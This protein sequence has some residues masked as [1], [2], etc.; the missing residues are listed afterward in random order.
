MSATA[1]CVVAAAIAGAVWPHPAPG[2]QGIA[3][4]G[5]VLVTTAFTEIGGGGFTTTAEDD[6]TGI[7]LTAD[8][9]ILTNNHVI[10]GATSVTVTDP[11]S[12]R[13]YP[14][15]VV[16][17]SV[18][19]DLAVIRLEGASGLTPA[20]L[21]DS[22][23]LSVGTAVTG[24]GNAH[25]DGLLRAASGAVI[26]LDQAV[27]VQSAG[28]GAPMPMSGMIVD[29][30]H[31]VEG[32]SGGPLLD[33][34]GRV[35]GV[36][37]ASNDGDPYAD[38]IASMAIPIE[39]ALSIVTRIRS[40]H[41]EGTVHVGPTASLG[42]IFDPLYGRKDPP[43][44]EEQLWAGL[45]AAGDCVMASKPGSPAAALGLDA[46]DYDV[47]VAIDGRKVTSHQDVVGVLNDL[48]P[49]QQVTVDWLSEDGHRHQG[50][51]TL[52]AGPPD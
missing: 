14:G 10:E 42:Y 51:T 46:T 15:T 34:S 52:A 50:I 37:D 48:A 8:G 45:T 5:V 4:P 16:G 29:N 40:G 32:D 33:A 28:A 31:T 25:G 23:G 22:R 30:A 38:S 27:T 26:A 21:G 19:E 41:S 11:A 12:G 39:D 44:C 17:Y 36:D 20:P 7:V 1:A 6:G 43:G 24:V 13:R 2:A 35:I 49:G 3:S 9:E 18:A 47:I